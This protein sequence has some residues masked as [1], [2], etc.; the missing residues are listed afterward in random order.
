VRSPSPALE[1]PTEA[2]VT[3]VTAVA[4]V[5][6]VATAVAVVAIGIAEAAVVADLRPLKMAQPPRNN[7][8]QLRQMELRQAQMD[9][10]KCE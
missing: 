7:S 6:V 4:V 5:I 8:Q 3:V 9:K 1:A 10:V 2:V